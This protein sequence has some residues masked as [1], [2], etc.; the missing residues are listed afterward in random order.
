MDVT[1]GIITW[2]AKDLLAQLLD[3]I[4]A[5]VENVRYEIVLV[6]NGSTD[7]TLEM[8]KTEYP[9]VI[10]LE[11]AANLGV[12]PAR[13]QLLRKARGRYILSLDVDS[14]LFP[15]G[16]VET[17][18]ST[19][20]KHPEAAIGGPKLVY[21]DGSLQLSCRPYPS[22][23]NILIEGTFLRK[24]LPHSRF[25]KGYNQEDWDHGSLRE[26]DWMYGA[27]LLIRS[28]VLDRIGLFDEAYFFL[29]ED[30]DLC[31]RARMAGYRVF[32]IPDAVICHHLEREERSMFSKTLWVHL[33]S[34][35]RY[36]IRDYLRMIGLKALGKWPA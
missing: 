5:S 1:I 10:L 8:V 11:N 31:F 14:T 13:N 6:D 15:N 30:I 12:A 26:V 7:G 25:V 36:L 20:D 17:L 22:P 4:R 9:E 3:S 27:A 35:R 29:Y 2:N 24:Y 33:R 19:M 32:Y 23:L 34:I 16:A 21:K 18:V 28:S